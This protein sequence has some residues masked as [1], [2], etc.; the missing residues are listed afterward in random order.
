LG[1]GEGLVEEVAGDGDLGGR[2]EAKSLGSGLVVFLAAVDA[3]L[4]VDVETKLE[5]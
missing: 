5:T 3:A 2:I 1:E 4:V